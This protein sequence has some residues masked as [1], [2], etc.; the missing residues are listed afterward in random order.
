[1]FGSSE[2]V[3]PLFQG[4]DDCEELSIIDVIIPLSRREGG[5]MIGTGVEVSI[6]V[7]LHEYSSRGSKGGIGH[8]EEWLGGVRH[9]DYW[10]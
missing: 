4:L 6:G 1:M 3:S 5:G 8:D 2:I 7:L 9:F 10:G